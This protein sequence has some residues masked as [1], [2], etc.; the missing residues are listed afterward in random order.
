MYHTLV[1]SNKSERLYDTLSEGHPQFPLV[2]SYLTFKMPISPKDRLMLSLED[3][4]KSLQLG[5]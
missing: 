4:M 3:I 5:Y 2:I 1:P